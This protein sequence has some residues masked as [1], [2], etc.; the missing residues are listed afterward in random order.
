MEGK[1]CEYHAL[2][3]ASLFLTLTAV[4]LQMTVSLSVNL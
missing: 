2:K 1:E 3:W 4:R